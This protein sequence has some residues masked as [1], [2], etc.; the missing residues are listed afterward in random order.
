MGGGRT[1]SVSVVT[2]QK[3]EVDRGVIESV[4]GADEFSLGGRLFR[5]MFLF[6]TLF[7][8]GTFGYYLIKKTDGLPNPPSVKNDIQLLRNC[9]YQ[10]AIL[11]T[12]VGFSDVLESEKTWR[13]TAFTVVMAFF[14]LGFLMYFI[15]TITAF[16]VGGELSQILERKKMM[17]RIEQ[18][19]QHFIVCGGG[20]NGRH[21][22]AELIATKRPFVVIEMDTDRIEKFKQLGDICYVQADATD[23]DTLLAAGVERA[24]GL[25]VALPND[26]D[27]LL[28]TISARQLNPDVRIVS[29]CIDLVNQK[30]L[31]KAGADAVVAP[32]MIGGLRMVSEMVRP[33]VVTFLDTM[34]RD[35][36][37][38]RFEDIRLPEGHKLVGKSLA[39]ANF[40]TIADVNIIATRAG[41]ESE[42]IYNPHGN[43]GLTAGMD[44]VAVGTPEEI[45]KI[46]R[47]LGV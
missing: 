7:C 24:E 34:L 29:R 47:H 32:A 19:S 4:F 21:V 14:G 40:P 6:I 42:F 5:P 39:E 25:V 22:V 38:I 23:D 37:A 31:L 45:L 11:L 20:E 9:T 8:F 16:I 33:T 30:K 12:G 43:L 36:R 26:K 15:S 27:N 41:E 13:G 17:K 35:R 44:L 1:A 46:R 28:I 3:P 2:G 10:T 18:L